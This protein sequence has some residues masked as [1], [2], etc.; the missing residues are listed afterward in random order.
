MESLAQLIPSPPSVFVSSLGD[1]A[2]QLGAVS[3]AL[4][5]AVPALIADLIANDLDDQGV[6]NAAK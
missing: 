3:V 6:A 4:G 5:A 2:V 1:R